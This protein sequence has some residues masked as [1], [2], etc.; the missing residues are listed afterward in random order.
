MI[1]NIIAVMR[2]DFECNAKESKLQR[3]TFKYRQRILSKYAPEAHRP[4]SFIV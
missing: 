1:D 3:D 4:E 2:A